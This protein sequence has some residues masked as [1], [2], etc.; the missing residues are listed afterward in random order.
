[1]KAE[2]LFRGKTEEGKWIYGSLK[3]G[4]NTLSINLPDSIGDFVIPETVG[5]FTG[6]RALNY[7][8]IFEGDILKSITGRFLIVSDS[9]YGN[10]TFT[11]IDTGETYKYATR[12]MLSCCK[13]VDNIHDNPDFVE[14]YRAKF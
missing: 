8:R 4:S 12:E 9:G 5:V 6:Y 11:D 3:G 13:I 7:K 14:T 10:W 2:V 1:M